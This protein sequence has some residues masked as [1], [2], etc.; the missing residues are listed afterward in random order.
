MAS[1]ARS[2][3]AHRRRTG[4]RASA[5]P[6]AAA[7]LAAT[8]SSAPRAAVARRAPRRSSSGRRGRCSSPGHLKRVNPRRHLSP[9]PVGLG[10]EG[11]VVDE[12]PRVLEP[13]EVLRLAGGAAKR[14]DAAPLGQ[15]APQ[16]VFVDLAPRQCALLDSARLVLVDVVVLFVALVE[17]FLHA[18][19]QVTSIGGPGVDHAGRP[20]VGAPLC[21]AHADTNPIF[22]WSIPVLAF[23]P[24]PTSAASAPGT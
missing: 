17:Y 2:P 18:G 4:R 21:A 3:A 6:L 11:R 1:P 24:G 7:H 10:I 14:E 20:V 19:F 15:L 13:D 5:A 22:G 23:G 8:G 9:G 16:C 12:R